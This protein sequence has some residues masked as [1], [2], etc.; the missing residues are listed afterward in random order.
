M[1][2]ASKLYLLVAALLAI[3]CVV[4]GT[5]LH[6]MH[7]AVGGMKT[8]YQDRIVPLRDLKEVADAYAVDIV[9]ATHKVH[10][11][12]FTM[13][14]GLASVD[15]ARARIG[16]RW[17]AYLATEQVAEEKALVD[18]ILPR[19]KAADA[20]VDKLRALLSRQDAQ[21]IAS[22][23][24]QELYPAIDPVSESIGKLVTVQ[25]DVAR[26]EYASAEAAYARVEGIST[27]LLVAGVL[28][29]FGVATVVIRGSVQR[30]LALT[31]QVARAVAEG[32]LA[33]EVPQDRRDEMGVL[34]AALGDMRNSL[35]TIVHGL[36]A[37]SDEVASASR[38]LADDTGDV[39]SASERQAQSAAAMAAAVEQMTVSISHVSDNASDARSES[40]KT[41]DLAQAG[42]QIIQS[43]ESELHTISESV[44]EASGKVHAMG[45][46]S[47]QITGILQVI[48][49]VA[50]QTN[51][52]ALNAAIEAARAGEQGRGFAVVAD[53][54]R[55]LAERT[56]QATLEISKVIGAVQDNAV[57]AVAAM[58]QTM[59]RVE[60]GVGL[61]R[62]ASE[63]MDDIS[64]GAQRMVSSVNE[65]S[66][67]LRE[68][69]IASNEIAT[70]VEQIARMSDENSSATRRAAE[71]ARALGALAEQ[72]H[73]AVA[74]FRT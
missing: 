10:N 4:G 56:A 67:A 64:G 18:E 31:Q 40:G 7:I 5:G 50:D 69:S 22:F 35:R 25:L 12:N 60:E 27:A 15:K 52:L 41:D 66:D 70:N 43:T 16:E 1:K 63:S 26:D 38:R 2:I 58:A 30:P 13:E 3:C 42:R 39:A 57:A 36:K 72:S 59:S 54:V 55:K 74:V 11:G 65:I 53:E 62:R 8:I 19:M 9:D 37:T 32:N 29:G 21:A 14:Q 23:A 47:K 68:Q 6:G 24:G 71:T 20:A 73:R 34:L 45:E 17:K 61:A 46:S 49:E 33:I 44:G 28:G 51:L 48:R